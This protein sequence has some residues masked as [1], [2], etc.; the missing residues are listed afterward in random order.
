MNEVTLRDYYAATADVTW[1][2]GASLEYIEAKSGVTAP[3]G[4]T[5][6][7]QVLAKFMIRAENAWRWRYSDFMMDGTEVDQARVNKPRPSPRSVAP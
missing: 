6:P 2:V 1:M 5:I 3:T 4:G 7:I